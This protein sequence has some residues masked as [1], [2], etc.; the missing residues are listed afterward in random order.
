MNIKRGKS[1]FALLFHHQSHDHRFF[2][3]CVHILSGIVRKW[4]VY[5]YIYL[6]RMKPKRIEI[7][8]LCLNALHE[9]A[10]VRNKGE[11]P[12]LAGHIWKDIIL[13]HLT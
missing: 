5:I 9:L 10:A 4:A 3:S 12:W 1:Y 7:N 13:R 6:I 2:F 11:Q 8:S